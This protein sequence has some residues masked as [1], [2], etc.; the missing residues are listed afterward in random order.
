MSG[1]EAARVGFVVAHYEHTRLLH[2]LEPNAA[3]AWQEARGVGNI[4]DDIL[5]AYLNHHK[6]HR[7]G[8]SSGR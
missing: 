1:T 5:Q 7:R 2:R 6:D 3:T 4:T 8:P